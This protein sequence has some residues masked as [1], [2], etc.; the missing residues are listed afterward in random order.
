MEHVQVTVTTT[1]EARVRLAG[2]ADI[3]SVV[4]REFLEAEPLHAHFFSLPRGPTEDSIRRDVAKLRSVSA[5]GRRFIE[6]R[7][8]AIAGIGAY[9]GW[10]ILPDERG[11]YPAIINKPVSRAEFKRTMI[12]DPLEYGREYPRDTFAEF[13][14]GIEE[15]IYA[16]IYGPSVY[17]QG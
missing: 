12:I 10:L 8:Q 2:L 3:S 14:R 11:A 4:A 13:Q 5:A 1:E 9:A 17:G 15:K 16:A 7:R 6:D